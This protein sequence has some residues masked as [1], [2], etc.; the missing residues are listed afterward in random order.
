MSMMTNLRVKSMFSMLKSP[1]LAGLASRNIA[2]SEVPAGH[3]YLQNAGRAT[4][5]AMP[6]QA[7]MP[8]TK[9]PRITYLSHE[10]ARVTRFFLSFGVG[11]LLS[12]SW[13]SPS[14]HSQPQMVRPSMR[15]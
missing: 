7:V 14:G 3:M 8:M 1:A 12:S 11:S 9:T 10:S 13:I 4:P 5:W 2:P 15:P 6:Y